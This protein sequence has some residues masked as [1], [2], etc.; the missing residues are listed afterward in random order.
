MYG[1]CLCM[2]Y[3]GSAT[4]FSA[5]ASPNMRAYVRLCDVPEG[6]GGI[7]KLSWRSGRD[8]IG[9][10]ASARGCKRE[11]ECA[12]VCLHGKVEAKAHRP[13]AC[14]PLIGFRLEWRGLII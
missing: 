3:I 5:L 1:L 9:R 11:E 14:T 10:S 2:C 6:L 8:L 4:L 7:A 12:M 13:N